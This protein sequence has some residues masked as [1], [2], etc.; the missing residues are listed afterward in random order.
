[1]TGPP[2]GGYATPAVPPPPAP[3]TGAPLPTYSP[4]GGYQATGY[5]SPARLHATPNAAYGGWQSEAGPSDWHLVLSAAARRLV[6]LFLVLGVVGIV[7]YTA[8][9]ITFNN[10]L[11]VTKV[12]NAYAALTG[13]VQS[14]EQAAKGCDGQAEAIDCLQQA[15]DVFAG[16]LNHFAATISAVSVPAAAKSTQQQ[17]AASARRS[18][19]DLVTLSQNP[20][21]ESNPQS[22]QFQEF[23]SDLQAVED[24]YA[25]LVSE[26]DADSIP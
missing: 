14:F 12:N 13:Q 23:E 25:Q 6:V 2:A 11:P 10:S 5:A 22:P 15:E 21:A 26:L 1:M 19:T 9:I 18:A 3:W 24:Q 17:L 8:V 16:N 20:T 4:G 7:A